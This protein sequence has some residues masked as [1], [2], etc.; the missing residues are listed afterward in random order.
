MI[1]LSAQPDQ[2]Y[3]IWQ[4]EIQLRNFHSLGIPKEQIQILVS[5]KTEKGVN[6]IFEQFIKENT[7]FANFYVYPDRRENPKYTSSIRPNILKQ[8]FELFPE[9]ENKTLFYHDSDI[10]FSRIPNIS[11]VENNEIVYVSDTR[12]Y[13]DI[14]YI[15]RTGSEQLLW[16]MAEI[17]GVSLEVIEKNKQ[18]TGGAQYILKN[19]NSNFWEKIEQD[20]ELL[21]KRM[22]E[23]N[24]QLWIA[25]YPDKKEYKS[26]KRG[27]QA[28]CADM[29]AVLWNLWL[30]EREVEIHP[31]MDFSW[32][33]NSV[34]EWETK[35]IQHYSG[36]IKEKDRYFRKIEYRNYMPWYDESLLLIPDTNCSYK[37]VEQIQ[38]R[39]REL[40]RDRFSFPESCII[41]DC[42]RLEEEQLTNVKSIR[43]YLRKYLDVEVYCLVNNKL[44]EQLEFGIGKEQLCSALKLDYVKLLWIPIFYTPDISIIREVLLEEGLEDITLCAEQIYKVDSLFLETFSKVLDMELLHINKNKF[45]IKEDLVGQ[46]MH[47]YCLPEDVEKRKAKLEN[48]VNQ[49][50]YPREIQLFPVAYSFIP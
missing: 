2:I 38:S 31:E 23:Y 50:N 45:N 35:A 39:R 18:H 36:N 30:S 48:I 24:H 28:W 46:H 42:M 16:D 27:I 17:V 44:L 29:W 3:F 40:D 10:L 7:H 20:C 5:Y 25:E 37:I 49:I 43:T 11:E 19:I 14:D 6:P 33:H 13:L 8:H 4:L 41:V 9:L 15:R 32:P 22:K 12:N 21:Y 26:K 47:L 34:E 1:Y